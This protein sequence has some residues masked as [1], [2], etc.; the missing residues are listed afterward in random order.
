MLGL[1][2]RVKQAEGIQFF[3]NH[4]LTEQE[5]KRLKSKEGLLNPLFRQAGCETQCTSCL[6]IMDTS[7]TP[8]RCT[9]CGGETVSPYYC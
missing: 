9:E 4:C 6:C 5:R 2:E 8:I 7:T 3:W 1:I